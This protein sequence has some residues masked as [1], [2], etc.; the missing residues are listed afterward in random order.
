MNFV[1]GLEIGFWQ[2]DR[3]LA[4]IGLHDLGAIVPGKRLSE[5]DDAV[6]ALPA[7]SRTAQQDSGLRSQT[8]FAADIPDGNDAL[9]ISAPLAI[10]AELA[11]HART[12][13]PLTIGLF[14]PAGSGKSFA[15][16]K[17]IRSIELLSTRA[18]ATPETPFIGE[19][20]TLRVDAAQLDGSPAVALACALH[21]SL[22]RTFP[23]LAA[24]AARAARDPRLEASE[25]LER[26]DCARRK[27]EAERQALDETKALCAHLADT[28]L[29]QTAGTQIDTYSAANAPLIKRLF[30]K[31]K[32]A[33]DPLPAFKDMAGALANAHGFGQRAG[34]VL[35]AFLGPKGQKK[36]IANA[37]LMLVCGVA[38]GFAIDG[39]AVWLGWLRA[40]ESSVSFAS[41]L[42]GHMDLLANVRTIVF[43]GAAA[44]LGANLSRALRLLKH[45]FRAAALLEADVSTRQSELDSLFAYQARRVE[46][47]AAEVEALSRL[48]AEAER[49]AGDAQPAGSPLSQSSPFPTDTA[50][51]QAQAFA[52]AA[53]TMMTAP[54][55]AGAGTLSSK[56]PR[57]IVLAID[58]LDAVPASRGREILGFARSL[59]KQ[60]YCLLIATDPARLGGAE[61]ETARWL[62]KWVDVPFQIGEIASRTNSSAFVRDLLNGQGASE[63]PVRDARA[64]ALD[65]PI[66]LAE[67]QNLTALAPLAGSSARALKRFVN[68][69]RLARAQNHDH[70]GPLAFMLALHAGGTQREI[71]ALNDALTNDDPEA[72]LTLD[73]CSERLS[74]A[75]ACVRSEQGRVSIAAARR[76][77]ATARLFSSNS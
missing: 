68:L 63:L 7:T 8:I 49:R 65:R 4:D 14:G 28:I 11:L 26:L 17:L 45:V 6:P 13:T 2:R 33:D 44:A 62:E 61:G 46:A 53:G 5:Q 12:E 77:A 73:Q 70:L 34:F 47:L 71:A 51:Q 41:W 75:F 56:M 43:L 50:A 32:I 18:A 76:A 52:A 22:A 64:S 21:A 37:A 9:G 42:E 40:N 67:T 25:T 66:S 57:R 74:N 3:V 24:E 36:L 60:G 35:Q 72:D 48:A 19:I 30:A 39:Q 27:L 38:L 59:F 20:A 16:T 1:A 10:L 69:Y 58:H 23:A 31:L 55:P 54:R 29:H 15:L